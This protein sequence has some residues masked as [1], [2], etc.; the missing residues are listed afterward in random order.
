ML[1]EG[2]A[3]QFKVTGAHRRQASSLTVTERNGRREEFFITARS[4]ADLLASLVVGR[5]W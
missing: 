4:P 3:D 2:A 1:T 5:A